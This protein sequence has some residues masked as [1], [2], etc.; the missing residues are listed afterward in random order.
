MFRKKLT[1]VIS[2]FRIVNIPLV[3]DHLMLSREHFLTNIAGFF[4]SRVAFFYCGNRHFL[5]RPAVVLVRI[6]V[7]FLEVLTEHVRERA[8]ARAYGASE[9]F[10]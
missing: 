2:S 3:P 9:E 10:S 7:R 1:R 8:D 4:A 5:G 6:R